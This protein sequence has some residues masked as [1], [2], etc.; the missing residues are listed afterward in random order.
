MSLLEAKGISKNYGKIKVLKDVDLA[1]GEGATHAIIGPNGAG[2]TT[3][4]RVLSGESPVTAGKI[5]YLDQDVTDV[6]AWRRVR[7]GIGRTFQVARIFPEMT[8]MESMLAATEAHERNRGGRH[9]ALPSAAV[10]AAQARANEVLDEVGL[11]EKADVVGAHL[12]HGDKKRLE[13]G[14]ALALNPKLLMLDEPMAGM[15]PTDRQA[16][17]ALIARLKKTHNMTLVLTEHDM[18]VVFT[19][20]TELTVLHHGEIIA[21]GDPQTVRRLPVVRELYLGKEASLAHG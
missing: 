21:S 20:A 7:M 3:L 12:S 5:R 9:V 18:D 19:L 1:V 13:L 8:A 6:P 15:S 4:F 10:H 2:K 16:A 17:V 14:M 11:A